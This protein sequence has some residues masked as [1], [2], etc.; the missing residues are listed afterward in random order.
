MSKTFWKNKKV[1]VT[2]GTGFIGSYLQAELVARGH[3]TIIADWL[4]TGAKWRNLAAHPPERIIAP[5]M[6]ERLFSPFATTKRE[7]LGFGLAI[8][9]RIV[10]A[11][12]GQLSAAPAPG[13]GAIFRFTLPVMEE[14]PGP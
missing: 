13:G 5:E 10:E 11:H 7:G 2:G 14:E 9:R 8:S 4:G 12:G 6:L 3:R 1:L